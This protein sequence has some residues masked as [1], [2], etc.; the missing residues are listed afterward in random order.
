MATI[1]LDAQRRQLQRLVGPRGPVAW[2][3]VVLIT[4]RLERFDR[5]ATHPRLRSVRR[6]T[7]IRAA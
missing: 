6:F 4:S 5:L 1:S 3:L 2:S 7:R